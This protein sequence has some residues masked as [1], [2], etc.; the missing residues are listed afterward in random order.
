MQ[1]EEG[2]RYVARNGLT[3]P[4]AKAQPH[5]AQWPWHIEGFGSYTD[6]GRF[7]GK[8]D[9]PKDLLAEAGQPTGDEAAMLALLGDD[10]PLLTTEGRK[11]VLSAMQRAFEAGRA[12]AVAEMEAAGIRLL[13]K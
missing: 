11:R 9:D 6:A 2:K 8:F 12:G 7:N 5:S 10:G 3:T 4:P 1:I 13:D